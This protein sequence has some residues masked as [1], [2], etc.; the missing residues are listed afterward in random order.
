[1]YVFMYIYAWKTPTLSINMHY[2]LWC[3]RD[4]VLTGS[5]RKLE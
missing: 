4:L 2:L 5:I 3:T 1:M